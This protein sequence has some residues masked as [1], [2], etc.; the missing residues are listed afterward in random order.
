MDVIKQSH[1]LRLSLIVVIGYNPLS[2]ASEEG[3]VRVFYPVAKAVIKGCLLVGARCQ[4]K[5]SENIPEHGA[6]LIVSNHLNLV[7]PPVL[8]ASI[9]RQTVFMAK[10]ELFRSA[11]SAYFVSSFGAFPVHRDRA[12]TKAVRQALQVLEDGLSLVIFPEEHRSPDG[13][14]QPAFPGAALIALRSG[15]PVLPIGI[16]G[17]EKMKGKT[18]PFRRPRV[19]V[20]IGKAF[21]LPQGGTTR[22]ELERA[23]GIIMEHIAALLPEQYR[24]YYRYETV[25]SPIADV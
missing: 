16:T 11:F 4:V 10:E 18:W 13:R 8:S 17:T 19:T 21:R 12:D 23:T 3:K 1:G 25:P 24:G 9:P 2:G 22:Q 15:A 6:L 7:D 5:G 20:N 14:L